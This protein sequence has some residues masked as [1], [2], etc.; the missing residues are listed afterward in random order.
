[1]TMFFMAKKM[2]EALEVLKSSLREEHENFK[3]GK[4]KWGKISGTDQKPIASHPTSDSFGSYNQGASL[5]VAFP[6]EGG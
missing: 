6:R 4:K 3:K 2:W 1:M 5:L